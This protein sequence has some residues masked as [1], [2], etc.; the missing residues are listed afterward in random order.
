MGWGTDFITNIYLSRQVF[1]TE[2][3]IEEEITSKKAIEQE[4]AIK[5]LR[6]NGYKILKPK[7]WEEI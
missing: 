6:E 4:N 7:T 3:E 5:L 1:R 2:G